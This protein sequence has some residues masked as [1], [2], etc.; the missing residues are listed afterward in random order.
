[1]KR[2]LSPVL[3]LFGSSVVAFLLIRLAPGD[4][5]LARLGLESDPAS[6]A[7]VRR[8]FALDQPMVVQYFRWLSHVLAGDFGR[9]LQ[10][11]RPVLPLLLG[12]LGP[13]VLLSLAALAL[14]TAIAIPAG[15]MAASRH[16]KL[17]DY[18]LSLAAICALSV[19]SFWLGMLLVLAF[20]IHLPVLPASGYVSPADDPGG[21]LLHLALPT[22]T[23]GIALAASSMRI[24]RAAMLEILG[25]DFIRTARAKGL[26]QAAVL[27]RHALP[28]AMVPIVT[29]LGIQMGQLFGG[30]VVTETLFAW[31]G[32]GKLTV[33]AVFA[34]DYPVVQGAVLLTA[35]L[36]LLINLLTDFLYTRLDARIGSV[37]GGGAS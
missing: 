19:P 29:L 8:T 16:E 6:V 35:A 11:G 37:A 13:T 7:A 34:R 3:V 32:L 33:D 14:S 26:R 4:P 36:F 24:T 1:M 30:V 9:S 10:T 20:A 22:L 17:S 18:S 23:L 31:P 2:L 28:N 12:S 15:V 5:A 27:C 21:F 25:A